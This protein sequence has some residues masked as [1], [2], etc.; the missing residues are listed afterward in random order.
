LETAASFGNSPRFWK[1]PPVLETPYHLTHAR[2]ALR[3]LANHALSDISAG[4]KGPRS[5]LRFRSIL[6]FL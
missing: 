5:D 4:R 3:A 6:Y 2:K 1:L